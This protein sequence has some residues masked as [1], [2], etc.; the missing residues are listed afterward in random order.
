MVKLATSPTHTQSAVAKRKI[1]V[2]VERTKPAVSKR[3]IWVPTAVDPNSSLAAHE[4]RGKRARKHAH[5]LWNAKT[6]GFGNIAGAKPLCIPK[7]PPE[8]IKNQ[9][10]V[11]DL[12]EMEKN[13]T[14]RSVILKGNS[15]QWNFSFI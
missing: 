11:A 1:S 8:A 5:R 7:D 6:Y 14:D 10:R 13:V 3:K 15:A 4:D 12:I 9:Q 2:P